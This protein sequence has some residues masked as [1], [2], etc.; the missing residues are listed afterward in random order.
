MPLWDSIASSRIAGGNY[1]LPA[2]WLDYLG[3]N[4]ALV[5]RPLDLELRSKSYS[6]GST[7]GFVDWFD[8]TVGLPSSLDIDETFPVALEV[9]LSIKFSRSSGFGDSARVRL[10]AAGATPQN[11]LT[12]ATSG[13]FGEIR[14]RWLSSPPTGL[15]TVTVQIDATDSTGTLTVSAIRQRGERGP[16]CYAALVLI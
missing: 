5:G 9:A 6:S 8:V 4:Y 13:N 15:A 14:C 12:V 7:A 10:T 2:L 1:G 3:R 16:D 11:E